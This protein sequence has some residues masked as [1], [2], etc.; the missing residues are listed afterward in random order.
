MVDSTT[1]ADTSAGRKVGTSGWLQ[2]PQVGQVGRQSLLSSSPVSNISHGSAAVT[3]NTPDVPRLSIVTSRR[4]T[5]RRTSDHSLLHSRRAGIEQQPRSL[6]VPTLVILAIALTS[7]A[8]SRHKIVHHAPDE[9][10]PHATW[11][12]RTGGEGGNDRLVCDSSQPQPTCALPAG[13]AAGAERASRPLSTFHLH[14][15][16]AAQVATYE[17]TLSIPVFEG[18]T[19]KSSRAASVTIQP[20]SPPRTSV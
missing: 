20:G 18:A 9:S 6:E 2:Q 1:S 10:Q 17:G 16:P 4:Y 19:E 5:V 12:L 3:A 14:L 11:E 15:H 13:S 7:V 8:C